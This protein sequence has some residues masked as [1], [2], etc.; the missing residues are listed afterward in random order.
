MRTAPA[1]SDYRAELARRAE[2]N[3]R[4]VSQQ[5]AFERFIGTSATVQTQR[6]AGIIAD[7]EHFSRVGSNRAAVIESVLG[8]RAGTR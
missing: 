8:R 4:T 2:S 1:L 7:A 3:S 6:D 5:A